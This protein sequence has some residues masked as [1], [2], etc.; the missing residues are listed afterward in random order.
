MDCR[1]CGAV[2]EPVVDLG[3]QP[4][5]RGFAHPSD[6]PGE[7]LPLK[8]GICV[9]CGLAQLADLSPPEPDEEINPWPFT[10]T[11]MAAHAR[12]FVAD[13]V[14]RGLATRSHRILSLASH[15]GHLEPFLRERDIPTTI[16]NAGL[17][18]TYSPTEPVDLLI[19]SYL[20][21]H[22][23]HPRVAIARI[24]A[25]L[26]PGGTLVLE[27]DSLLATVEGGEWDAVGHGHPVYLSLGWLWRE[28]GA[29]GLVVFDA[30]PQPVYGG[31]VR[32][33]AR[34]GGHPEP[35]VDALLARERSV[36]IGGSAGLAPLAEAVDRARRVVVPYLAGAR[37][38]GR[39]IAGYGAPARAITFLNALEIG[40]DLLAFVVDRAAAKQ[41]RTI[42]GV[43]IPILAPEALASEQPDDVL[44][45]TWN[46]VAE[47][48]SALAPLVASGTRLLVAIPSLADVTV[49]GDAHAVAGVGPSVR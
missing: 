8:L 21:A 47:V 24:A 29:V 30:V 36:G 19:D 23:E 5:S 18:I 35:S 32:V 44:I 13:L 38:A 17:S 15:G 3:L 20:L 7:R 16:G 49:D 26:A 2:V 10:S 11:T 40:P 6:P 37:V 31:A 45:L 9:G 34:A 41:G 12:G 14:A 43:R 33:F 39:R 4:T 46:L 27:F 25:L 48:R 22:L 42:A 1:A 28:L